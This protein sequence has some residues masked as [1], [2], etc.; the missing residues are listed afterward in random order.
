MAVRYC[1]IGGQAVNAY[2]EP[3]VS[4]DLVVVVATEQL[5]AV[6]ALLHDAF[7]VERFPH[8]LNIS[9]PDSDVRIQVQTDPRYATFG[10][11]VLDVLGHSM[12]V[13]ALEDV[14]QGKVWAA[15]D[16]ARRPSKRQKDLTDIA[17]ILEANP[18]LRSR[19]PQTLLD[20]LL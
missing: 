20:R 11:R 16:P 18:I 6:E 2:I 12:P 4:L 5:P 15:L 17:R 14:L 10:S 8:S 1:I 19:V 9:V 7:V 13:A 3:L